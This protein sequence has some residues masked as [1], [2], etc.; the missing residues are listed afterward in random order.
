ML[1]WFL[2]DYL[3]TYRVHTGEYLLI[4]MS[5]SILEVT[6]AAGFSGS[7]R[8]SNTFAGYM[9]CTLPH[10]RKKDGV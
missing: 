9:G 4:R 10:Y 3:I 6:L 5:K 8:S 1:G 2:M 7:S